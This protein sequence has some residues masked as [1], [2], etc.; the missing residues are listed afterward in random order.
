MGL[1][2]L[3]IVRGVPLPRRRFTAWAALYFVTFVAAPVLGFALVVDV[4]LYLVFTRLL[5]RCY[6]VLC[7]FT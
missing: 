4:V 6:G 7:L 5:D 2:K 1:F 3:R